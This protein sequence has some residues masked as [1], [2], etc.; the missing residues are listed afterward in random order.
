LG[1]ET[2]VTRSKE[3]YRVTQDQYRVEPSLRLPLASRL[4]L[5]VGPALTYVSTDNRPS[6]FLATVNPYG[7]GD[8]GELGARAALRFDSRDRATAATRGLNLEVSGAVHPAW[9]DVKETF[10]EVAGET[11][12]FLSPSMPLDPTLAF[13]AGG[14]KL[15]GKY[16]YFEA[17]FIGGPETVRLGR[18]NRFAGDASAYGSAELRVRL[19]RSM[20]IVPTDFGVFGLADAGRVWLENE[21]SDTWHEALGGGVWFGFLSR[22]NTLSLA[23]AASDER[24]SFYVR[25][26]FGF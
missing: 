26:G 6:R 11:R 25:A 17:A 1:N 7:A 24:T 15:W 5:T 21:S 8:F 12:F 20:I 2:R 19:G 10:G 4:T 22:A 23:V 13:R 16:P 9:W 3:Y 18:E 14:R